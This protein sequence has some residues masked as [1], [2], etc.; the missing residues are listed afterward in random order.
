MTSI[1]SA[2]ARCCAPKLL[3]RMRRSAIEGDGKVE[4]IESK[5]EWM[6]CLPPSAI[7]SYEKE[8]YYSYFVLLLEDG[9][10]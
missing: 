9:D 10:T 8:S 2:R 6:L 5:R 1:N 7:G 3:R 4:M